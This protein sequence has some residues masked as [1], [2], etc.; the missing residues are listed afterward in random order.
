LDAFES[1][2]VRIY[3]EKVA[4]S[5][6]GAEIIIIKRLE[7]FTLQNAARIILGNSHRIAKCLKL[8]RKV[9]GELAVKIWKSVKYDR[10]HYSGLLACG[11]VWSCPTCAEKIAVKRKEE[12]LEAKKI[13]IGRGNSIGLMTFTAPHLKTNRVSNLVDGF[14]EAGRKLRAHWSWR[15]WCEE[16]GVE[17]TVS[18]LEVTW[19]VKAGWHVHVHML[20]FFRGK[21][22]VKS[23]DTTSLLD[24]WKKSCVKS[25]LREPNERGLDLQDGAR[26]SSYITKLGEDGEEKR[27]AVW[28]SVEELTKSHVKKGR[29]GSLTPWDFL[30]LFV[31][32]GDCIYEKLFRQFSKAFAGKK[33]LV[34]SHGLFAEIFGMTRKQKTDQEL[35]D[36]KEA[37]AVLLGNLDLPMWRKVLAADRR[38][39]LLE[40]ARTKGWEGVLAY[41]GNLVVDHGVDAS[42][43][44]PKRGKSST[45]A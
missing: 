34:W 26:A 1:P 6:E 35:V 28:G 9:D 11:L 10:C 8:V 17:G 38:G 42:T 43:V 2:S 37:D 44:K 29:D 12:L 45:T 30:R 27:Y 15:K 16:N 5:S 13:W 31:E 3:T 39:E 33:Q 22:E 41:I 18:A 20:V 36:G 19:G 21:R 32:T 23:M 40:V 4:D 14:R 24:T 7:K 25:G